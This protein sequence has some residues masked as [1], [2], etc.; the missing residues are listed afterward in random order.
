MK[1]GIQPVC[2]ERCS[3]GTLLELLVTMDERHL[4]STDASAAFE[5]PDAD[6][7][8]AVAEFYERT[9]AMP[10]SSIGPPID[11]PIIPSRRPDR[12]GDF[13]F[14]TGTGATYPASSRTEETEN[15]EAEKIRQ[16]FLDMLKEKL[17]D[18]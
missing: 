8:G 15:P 10:I 9:G 11:R 16:E 18:L 1:L 13:D 6:D 7:M 3:P 5:S 12:I 2:A 17:K 14:T 4:D